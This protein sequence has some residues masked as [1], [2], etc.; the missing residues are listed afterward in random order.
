M[1]RSVR[2]GIS[3]PRLQWREQV[4]LG[5]SRVFDC[6]VDDWAD[7]LFAESFKQWAQ[8]ERRASSAVA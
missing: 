2:V 6:S 8:I 3:A 4:G 5:P 7:G 1:G